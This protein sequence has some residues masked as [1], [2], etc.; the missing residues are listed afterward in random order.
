MIPEGEKAPQITID[1]PKDSGAVKVEIPVEHPTGGTVAVIVQ[2]NGEEVPVK[3]YVVTKDGIIVP[4]D[5]SAVIMIVDRSKHFVDVH[6][7]NHWAKDNVDFAT[8]RGLFG[9]TSDTQFSPDLAMTRGMLVTVLYRMEDS[10]AQPEENLGYPFS[11]VT[12]DDWL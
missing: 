3:E 6:D 8:A 9:G 11:D 10:P 4:L 1:M 12:S 2:P 5:G 7:V